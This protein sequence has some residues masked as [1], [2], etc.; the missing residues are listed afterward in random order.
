MTGRIFLFLGLSFAMLFAAGALEGEV[1][2]QAL[3]MSAIVMFLLF[4]G[5]TLGITYWAAKRTK[6]AKDFYTAGGGI[7]GFQNGLA[8]AGDYQEALE[9]LD[10]LE[11]VVI[12]LAG[13]YKQAGA[14]YLTVREMGGA[15][16]IL[17][18]RT[19]ASVIPLAVTSFAASTTVCESLPVMDS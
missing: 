2:E 9:L 17:S 16:N 14:D 4:V 13:I 10:T 11:D 3:N 1:E 6:T 7:T 8:I 5:G 18:P 15:E 19:F 12:A